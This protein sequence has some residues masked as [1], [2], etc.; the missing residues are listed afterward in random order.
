[1]NVLLIL[2]KYIIFSFLG[3][4]FREEFV[5]KKL[6]EKLITFCRAEMKLSNDY[7]WLSIFLLFNEFKKSNE[8]YLFDLCIKNNKKNFN[9]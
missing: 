6:Y 5:N 9:I 4:Y 1:M 7:K 2:V 3:K 8:K